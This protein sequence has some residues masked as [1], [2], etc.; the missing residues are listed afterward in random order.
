[1]LASKTD[2]RKKEKI[3][4]KDKEIGNFSEQKF[5][6]IVQEI[7]VHLIL[8]ILYSKAAG[9][10]HRKICSRDSLNYSHTRCT[11]RPL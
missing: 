5:C 11:K 2:L 7:F 9:L 4:R 3:V 1:M 10:G 6:Q 8:V